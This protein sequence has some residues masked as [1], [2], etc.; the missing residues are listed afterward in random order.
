M[1]IRPPDCRGNSD[2]RKV[3]NVAGLKVFLG[4]LS[5]ETK[6]LCGSSDLIIG[7][8]VYFEVYSSSGLGTGGNGTRASTLEGTMN[9]SNIT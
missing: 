4:K 5:I 8:N 6:W 7:L 1:K 3:L 9:K 2:T